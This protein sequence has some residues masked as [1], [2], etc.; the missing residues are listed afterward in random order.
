MKKKKE[1]RKGE[2]MKFFGNRHQMTPK[3]IESQ[4]WIWAQCA[5]AN[6]HV[7]RVVY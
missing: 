2:L 1:K 7:L 6:E 4:T 3:I 5:Q